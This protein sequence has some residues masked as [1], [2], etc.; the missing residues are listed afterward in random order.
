MTFTPSST[1]TP[2]DT[3][4][5]PVACVPSEIYYGLIEFHT[6]K[7]HVDI[8]NNYGSAI[9]ISILH[10]IWLD[11]GSTR[12]DHIEFKGDDIW[13][14][15]GGVFDGSP[16]SHFADSGP[17]FAWDS[18]DGA[19]TMDDG[20][21]EMLMFDFDPNVDLPDGSYTLKITFDGSA[22]C[23]IETAITK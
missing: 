18:S 15:P 9:K 21:T 5:G 14:T 6:D 20:S 13:D 12:L 22:N 10:F 16:P 7:L 8:T 11:A 17:E 3:P 1:R 2:T 23:Y 19:R 4:S